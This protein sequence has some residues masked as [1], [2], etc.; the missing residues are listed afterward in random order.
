MPMSNIV[1]Y[2]GYALRFES[3]IKKVINV[4]SVKDMRGCVGVKYRLQFT[5]CEIGL[6]VISELRSRKILKFNC[7][8][9]KCV[10]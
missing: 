5:V 10:A 4:K 1:D 9:L 8:E 3:K 2:Y 7:L 6:N